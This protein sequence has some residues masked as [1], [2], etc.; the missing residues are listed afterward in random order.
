MSSLLLEISEPGYGT[1]KI[2]V[3]SDAA[4]QVES[5]QFVTCKYR[6]GIRGGF[7]VE[8]TNADLVTANEIS[9]LLMSISGR[10]TLALLD[11]A[12]VLNDGTTASTRDFSNMTKAAMLIALINEEQANGG[13]AVLAYDFSASVD[14]NSV[15]WT[16]TDESMQ[17]T[18]GKSLLDVVREIAEMGIEFDTTIET[19]GTFTL[20]AYSTPMG[21]DLSATI[22]L[23]RGVNCMEVKK[24]E[25]GQDIKNALVVKYGSGD[26]A[27]YTFVKDDVS[28]A[29]H[30][31]RVGIVD[32]IDANNSAQALIYGN[33]KLLYAK[34]PK[35]ELSLRVWDN[36][37]KKVFAD[38]NL[39]DYVTVDM[40]GVKEIYRIRRIQLEWDD[41]EKAVITI[42]VNSSLYENEIRQSNDIRKLFEMWRR[43]NDGK[44]IS[45]PF[46]AAIGSLN[47]LATAGTAIYAM[48]VSDA[49]ILYVGGDFTKVGNVTV[50]YAAKY[51]IASGVWSKLGT[52]FNGI[53][54]AIACH[55]TNIYFGGDFTTADGGAVNHVCKYDETGGTFDDM[56]SGASGLVF[57]LTVDAGNNIVYVGGRFMS[58]ATTPIATHSMAAWNEGTN[59]WS[60]L[61]GLSTDIYPADVF[62][63]AV[64]GTLVFAGGFAFDAFGAGALAVWDTGDPGWALLGTD[65]AAGGHCYA[66]AVL[67]DYL[68]IG[69][70]FTAAGGV[71]NTQNL[72][73]W[74]I[75]NVAFESVDGGQADDYVYALH[76]DDVDLYIG[77]KFLT[78]GASSLTVNR[79]AKW[80]GGSFEMLTTGLDGTCYALTSYNGNIGAGGIF[81]HAGDKPIKFLGAYITSLEN[82]ADYLETGNG[83]SAT[84]YVHP[85]HSGDVTSV[86]DGAQTIAA[87]VVDNTKLANMVTETVK[88]R[89]TA[90]TGDPEDVTLADLATAMGVPGTQTAKR[91]VLSD[92]SGNLATS[93]YVAYDDST[94]ILT[95]GELIAG[96]Y[97]SV[98]WNLSSSIS[99]V[100]NMITWGIGNST[101]FKGTF[102][103]GTIDAPTAAQST[104][105]F[106]RFSGA[107]YD[108]VT[109]IQNAATSGEM[110]MVA[111]E[112]QAAGAHGT[113]A[114]IWLAPIG[115]A[116][117]VKIATISQDGKINLIAGGEYLVDGVAIGG[118]NIPIVT[119]DPVA[120]G[121]GD[122]WKL[123]ETSTPFAD[124][125]AMGMTCYT[126]F[127]DTGITSPLQLSMWDATA[128]T[129]IRY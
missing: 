60:A 59:T 3:L 49:G 51:D 41:S 28:I 38:Y 69:G 127:G 55:G 71:S 32:A 4:Q 45:L 110:R 91:V 116:T 33:A 111:A 67:G 1:L 27:G 102:A 52:G 115:S 66:L 5:G 84:P 108:G 26:I 63:I 100:L 82:L 114:E 103:R 124:G 10:G 128:G 101:R 65:I 73:K 18:V 8:N 13:L 40:S 125:E 21:S 90:G 77:G 85:N 6:G 109:G 88:A 35:K 39:G 16:D 97:Q 36:L 79:V 89:L 7:F 57:A 75:V 94:K 121:D 50:G 112:N 46:W 53:V 2:P 24:K 62:A 70:Q 122:M 119:S 22:Y 14:S 11:R 92:A 29:A 25:M 30:G 78:I 96:Y 76:V 31:R 81:L 107:G 47:E 56:D 61:D 23:R 64:S 105:T 68:Y 19:D 106:V 44:E 74:H 83:N 34:N 15:A 17:F 93:D 126:Y 87:G 113:N 98:I 54:R 129:I 37:G 80:N 43:A 20:H 42:G 120:P 12:I 48:A 123:R 117:M 86:G 72:A 58:V 95:L 118:A 9:G 104:D 99:R